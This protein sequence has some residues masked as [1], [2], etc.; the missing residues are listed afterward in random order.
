M[1]YNF[2]I[3]DFEGPLD[4]LLHLI[5]EQDMDIMNIEIVKLTDQYLEFIDSMKEK[6][7]NIASEYLILASELMYIKSKSLLPNIKDEDEQEELTDL[8]ENLINRFL[9]FIDFKMFLFFLSSPCILS[10]IIIILFLNI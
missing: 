8:K 7:L 10:P 5:K 3:N 2:K 4:L 9:V 6:N 1:E